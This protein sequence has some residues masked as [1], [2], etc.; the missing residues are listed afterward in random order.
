MVFTVDG[1]GSA[2]GVS[3]IDISADQLD[4]NASVNMRR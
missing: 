1:Q 4:E 2:G 3:L